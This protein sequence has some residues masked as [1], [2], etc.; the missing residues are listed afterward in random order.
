V[1]VEVQ[2]GVTTMFTH[3]IHTLWPVSRGTFW[4][5]VVDDPN[6][7]PEVI[8]REIVRRSGVL[9]ATRDQPDDTGFELVES[10]FY[11]HKPPGGETTRR[12]RLTVVG[13]FTLGE[14]RALQKAEGD[15]DDD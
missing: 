8:A 2:L 9:K 10:V 5:P 14:F 11:D 7:P 12:Y 6:A 15:S 13:R 4:R 3:K 1:I